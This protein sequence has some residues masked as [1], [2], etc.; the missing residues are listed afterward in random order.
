M[1]SNW[2][3]RQRD[4]HRD[5]ERLRETEKLKSL[6]SELQNEFKD[7]KGHRV[8]DKKSRVIKQERV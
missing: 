2:R 1:F 4:R 8:D 5:I 3:A 6:G 7:D